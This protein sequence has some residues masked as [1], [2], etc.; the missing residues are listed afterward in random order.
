MDRSGRN[1]Q[2]THLVLMVR[3]WKVFGYFFLPCSTKLHSFPFL[4]FSPLFKMLRFKMLSHQY[5]SFPIL[6]TFSSLNQHNPGIVFYGKYII[7]YFSVALSRVVA[8]DLCQIFRVSSLLYHK[9]MGSVE[10][11]CFSASTNSEYLFNFFSHRREKKSS[12]SCPQVP[13]PHAF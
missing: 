1:F 9:D 2:Q 7:L 12:K 5:V 10:I 11:E 3:F 6:F 4:P 13:H 8:M